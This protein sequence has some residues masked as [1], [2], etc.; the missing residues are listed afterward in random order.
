MST[1]YLLCQVVPLLLLLLTS[2]FIFHLVVQLK[3]YNGIGC[4][5]ILNAYLSIYLQLSVYL[6][7]CVCA[8]NKYRP[9]IRESLNLQYR[10]PSIT[11][12]LKRECE[13]STDRPTGER[14]NEEHA[15]FT[16]K[17]YYA[18]RQRECVEWDVLESIVGLYH[19]HNTLFLFPFYVFYHTK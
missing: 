1:F 17:S 11:C 2:F 6:S 16:V 4:T 3:C 18:E 19:L 14:Q 12:K 5:I 7:I 15:D 13:R 9:F 8:R 10:Q